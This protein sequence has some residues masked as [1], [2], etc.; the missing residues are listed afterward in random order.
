MSLLHEM[1]LSVEIESLRAQL[2]EC[3]RG[4]DAARLEIEKWHE[5]FAKTEIDRDR[6]RAAALVAQWALREPL[7]DWK[8]EC[9]R[10]ALDALSEA[11]AEVKP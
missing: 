8:G 10:K 3:Q 1:G 7:N 4:R 9:E 6:L 2:A 5:K 11:L